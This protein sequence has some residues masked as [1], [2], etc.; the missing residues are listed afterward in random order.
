M[1]LTV[2]RWVGAG[3]LFS[4][5]A[6][7]G[8]DS[9]QAPSAGPLGFME[10]YRLALQ[11]DASLLVARS[12]RDASREY[13][14]QALAGLLPSVA[15]SGGRNRNDAHNE[16]LNSQGKP[17][18]SDLAYFSD[19][20]SLTLRQPMFR[21]GSWAQLGFA[22][23]QEQYGEASYD[24][25]HQALAGKLAAAYSQALLGEELVALSRV[26]REALVQQLDQAQRMFQA[27]EGTR[28]E[29]DEAQANHDLVV[30]EEIEAINGRDVAFRSL[31]EIIGV[32]P[33]RLLALAPDRLPV[34]APLSDSLDVLL[35]VARENNPDLVAA[36]ANL[37]AAGQDVRKARAGHFPTLDLV[38]ARRLST[39][40]SNNTVNS[41]YDTNYVGIEYNIPIFSGGGVQA[42]VRQALAN[43]EKSGYQ[44]DAAERKTETSLRK[45]YLDVQTSSAKI[46]ALR[47]AVK[48]SETALT[49]SRKGLQAG[50]STQLD[51]LNAIHR[52]YSARRDLVRA[53]FDFVI[54][55]VN[56]RTL[57]GQINESDVKKIAD[58]FGAFPSSGGNG[59]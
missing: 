47:L 21:M 20:K 34:A 42:G 6:A 4:A 18:T 2:S 17:V 53:N 38:V 30:A 51:V 48:S 35:E 15:L 44:V 28:T 57:T 11:N 39:S 19:I 27:G 52:L 29:V 31:E 1:R 37:E 55:W 58:W 24:K 12:A 26:H 22:Q 9:R 14:P 33:G 43:K 16:T 36:R 40:E 3:L 49:S 5:F 59:S 54:A 50:I 46:R 25:E 41:R 56:V 32:R 10:A 7:Y 13:V 23:A 8:A 45:S